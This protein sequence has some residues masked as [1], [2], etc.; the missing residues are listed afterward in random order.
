MRG[1]GCQYDDDDDDDDAWLPVAG[2]CV[3]VMR[4]C[5]TWSLVLFPD[6]NFQQIIEYVSHSVAA[7]PK[8]KKRQKS[9]KK[10]IHYLS[11]DLDVT[12]IVV[13][14]VIH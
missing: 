1:F 12:A 4:S 11:I 10:T 2:F 8:R 9:V 5:C 14:S 7:T 3:V 6:I 13:D